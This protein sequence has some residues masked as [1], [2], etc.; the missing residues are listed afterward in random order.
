M[1]SGAAEQELAITVLGWLNSSR[2]LRH[3]QLGAAR[4][5][6]AGA[7]AVSRCACTERRWECVLVRETVHTDRAG[8]REGVRTHL[9]GP[10]GLLA[11]RPARFPSWGR[12]SA[13]WVCTNSARFPTV[14]R[15]KLVYV[16]ECIY[17]SNSLGEK[18]VFLGRPATELKNPLPYINSQ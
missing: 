9:L 18:I 8:I 12:S 11:P 2:L 3:A 16:Y 5:M 6:V 1:K 14:L 15:V 4:F 10:S 7:C 13:R 17:I